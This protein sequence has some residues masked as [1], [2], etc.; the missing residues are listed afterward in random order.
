MLH[1][2]HTSGARAHPR[3]RLVS[4]RTLLVRMLRR[5]F[6][7]V[8]DAKIKLKKREPTCH[9]ILK[10]SRPPSTPPKPPAT[11][12]TRANKAALGTR[13]RAPSFR[14]SCEVAPCEQR[15]LELSASSLCSRRGQVGELDRTGNARARATS[16]CR[17]DGR[18][19]NIKTQFSVFAFQF[20]RASPSPQCKPPL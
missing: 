11:L 12:A 3:S 15:T 20:A 7:R 4:T 5:V 16:V 18:R 14:P 17:C 1:R 2:P 8:V 10:A 13:R 6:T 9:E 19:A